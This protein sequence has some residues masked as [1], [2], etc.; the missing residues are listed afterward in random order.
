MRTMT[1]FVTHMLRHSVNDPEILFVNE[2]SL[3]VLIFLRLSR[4]IFNP[5]TNEWD[6][7]L[8]TTKNKNRRP[9]DRVLLF[10]GP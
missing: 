6:V 10:P 1:E 7:I 5:K 3:S 2:K 8:A 9:L 4:S